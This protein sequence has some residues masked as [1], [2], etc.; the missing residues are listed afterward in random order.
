MAI[1]S[2]SVSKRPSLSSF[3]FTGHRRTR[4]DRGLDKK[5]V[6]CGISRIFFD[7][8]PEESSV[9]LLVSISPNG[10]S[11]DHYRHVLVWIRI[12]GLEGRI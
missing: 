7:R 12:K 9:E 6:R 5:G 11:D 10:K 8:G 1:P 3:S 4:P 2:T